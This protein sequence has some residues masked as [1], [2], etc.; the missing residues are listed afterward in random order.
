M[1]I[2]I[3]ILH[4]LV[5]FLCG[6]ADAASYFVDATGGDDTAA[7]TSESAA[8]QTLARVSSHSAYPGFSPGDMIYLKKGETWRDALDMASSGTPERPITIDAYGEDG[9]D[10]LIDGQDILRS[11]IEMNSEEWITIR[12]VHVTDA[13]RHCIHSYDGTGIVL[14]SIEADR[15]GGSANIYMGSVNGLTVR[16]VLSHDADIEHGIYISGAPSQTNDIQISYSAFYDNAGSG[17]KINT[18]T[19]CRLQDPVLIYNEMYGNGWAGV[20]DYGSESAIIAFNRIYDNDVAF[21]LRY[22]DS[23]PGSFSRN[24]IITN[25]TLVGKP[26]SV[27]VRNLWL[28]DATTGVTFRNNISYLQDPDGVHVQVDQGGSFAS[29][30]YNDYSG[31]QGWSHNAHLYTSLSS[32]QAAVND[33][34]NSITDDPGFMDYDNDDFIPTM[35]SHVCTASSADSYMG[36]DP[37]EVLPEDDP[38]PGRPGRPFIGNP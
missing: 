31:D 36:A 7:G 37:C 1:L 3:L 30:D 20:D 5:L 14:E 38:P 23:Q 24:H 34:A 2:L 19:G 21:Y 28:S 13:R 25:N 15:A 22:D 12:N 8:W 29:T 35:W 9:T 18:G 16:Y 26:H 27:A 33:D 17:I 32:W 11:C 10:P 6:G 4:V